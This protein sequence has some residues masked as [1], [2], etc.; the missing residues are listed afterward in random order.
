MFIEKKQLRDFVLDS[1]LVSKEDFE[2]AEKE[3]EKTGI[4]LGEELVREGKISEDDLRRM[5]A[6]VLGIPFVDLRSQKIDFAIL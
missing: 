3:A 4:G 5:Q 1:G 6:Y 2:K